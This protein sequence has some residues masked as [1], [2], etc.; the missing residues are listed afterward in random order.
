MKNSIIED[1]SRN[2][3]KKN[4]SPEKRAIQEKTQ[5]IQGERT[6][7]L[8]S[9]LVSFLRNPE[10]IWIAIDIKRANIAIDR[11]SLSKTKE[12]FN[13]SIVATVSSPA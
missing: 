5:N 10:R 11:E 2:T 9:L 13:I 6:K 8:R 12:N 4:Q 7:N 1:I 3:P